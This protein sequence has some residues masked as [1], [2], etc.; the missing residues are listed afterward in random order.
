MWQPNEISLVLFWKM[1]PACSKSCCYN[2]IGL[3]VQFGG[4]IVAA[5][6]AG[7]VNFGGA[8]QLV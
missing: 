4:A 3:M 6:V 7:G 2:L 5:V 8:A 1:I